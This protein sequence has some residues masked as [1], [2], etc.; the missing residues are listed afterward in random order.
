MLL[1][2]CQYNTETAQQISSEKGLPI[3]QLVILLLLLFCV[4]SLPRGDKATMPER[5]HT[6]KLKNEDHQLHA[7]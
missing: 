4:R 1:F 3:I 7:V 6:E 5:S 2:D